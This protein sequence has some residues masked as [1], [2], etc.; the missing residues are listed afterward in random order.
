MQPG[1]LQAAQRTL[2]RAAHLIELS[3]RQ[4]SVDTTEV[5]APIIYTLRAGAAVGP[6]SLPPSGD[7][8]P[9]TPSQG[10]PY[11]SCRH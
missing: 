10:T 9:T 5:E 7:L 3:P 6:D 11:L 8:P 1:W 4:A 2:E